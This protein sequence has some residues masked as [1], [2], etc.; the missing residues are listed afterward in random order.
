MVGKQQSTTWFVHLR[1]QRRATSRWP[2]PCVKPGETLS[3][4]P[5]RIT[6]SHPPPSPLQAGGIAS[7][8]DSLLNFGG[9]ANLD[10]RWVCVGAVA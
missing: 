7:P 2:G 9:L 1:Y 3:P 5:N 4:G 8:A 6:S 10:A